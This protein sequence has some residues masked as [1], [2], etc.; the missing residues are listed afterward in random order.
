VVHLGPPDARRPWQCGSSPRI[1]N[2]EGGFA[3]AYRA[4]EKWCKVDCLHWGVWEQPLFTMRSCNALQDRMHMLSV[5]GASLS[6]PFG[7]EDLW[8]EDCIGGRG[9]AGFLP[10][11]A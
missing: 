10:V 8:V 6:A 7:N 3:T 9:E 1:A 2:Y 4:V 5:G 11:W